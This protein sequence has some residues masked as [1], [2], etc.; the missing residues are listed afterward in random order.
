MKQSQAQID[1]RE[2]EA[3][4]GD[5]LEEGVADDLRQHHA[6]H[7]AGVD[8][9]RAERDSPIGQPAD[10]QQDDLRRAPQSERIGDADGNV[11]GDH[12]EIGEA[13]PAETHDD[14]DDERADEDQVG[15]ERSGEQPPVADA[16][17]RKVL[18]AK[19]T[20]L[21][22]AVRVKCAA[23]SQMRVC[24]RALRIGS[25][26]VAVL[27]DDHVRIDNGIPQPTAIL[28]AALVEVR[29]RWGVDSRRRGEGK[30]IVPRELN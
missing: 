20:R 3:A 1:L 29:V 16:S 13:Q 7:E 2:E 26:T 8:P 25:V 23:T 4:I 30:D 28:W 22:I 6:D 24:L 10:D 18:P 9:V 21:T 12:A 14:D 11:A 27:G 5:L 19:K 15:E 17:G